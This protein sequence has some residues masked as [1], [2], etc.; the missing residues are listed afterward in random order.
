MKFLEILGEKQEGMELRMD[1]LG[2]LEFRIS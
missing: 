1:F 2:K